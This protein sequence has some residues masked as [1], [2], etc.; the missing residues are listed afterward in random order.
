MTD[1]CR[2]QDAEDFVD[3]LLDLLNSEQ[4]VFILV[5]IICLRLPGSAGVFQSR[6]LMV[7]FEAF[8][9]ASPGEHAR[10]VWKYLHRRDAAELN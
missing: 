5:S 6:G 7:H 10:S 3:S 2:V 4:A 1:L 9:S 8:R